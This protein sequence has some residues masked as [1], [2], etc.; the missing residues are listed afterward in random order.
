MSKWSVIKLKDLILF[1]IPGEWGD[2]PSGAGN[3][4]VLRAADFT[5]DC[6]LRNSVGVI[7]NIPQIKLPNRLLKNGDI[8]IEKSGGSPEQPVGRIAF[9]DR[10]E[11]TQIYSF[12]NFLQLLRVSDSFDKEFVYYLM[13]Y[14]YHSGRVY[15][16]QQQTTGIINLKLEQYLDEEVKIPDRTDE[17][18]KI[19][20]IL[21][22]SD[23][24]IE[25]TEALIHKYQQIKAG[26]MHDL[27]TRGLTAD[28]QLRPPREQAPDLYQETPIGWIPKD[29]G[30]DQFGERISVIDPNP[31]HR[32]P[33]EVEEG[34]PICSTEN[35]LGEN[36]FHLN[37]NRLVPYHTFLEQNI[38]CQFSP[39]DVVFARK[40]KIG[41]ARRYGI[42]KKAFSHTIV[43]MKPKEKNID[44]S[45]L[46]W[47]ARS[48]W[49][50]KAIE[51]SM[52]TNSG[53]P[54]LGVAFINKVKVPFPKPDDQNLMANMLDAISMNIEIESDQLEKYK[55]QKSGLMHDLLTGRVRVKVHESNNQEAAA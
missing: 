27:F 3:A 9:F 11:T 19:R 16:Y 45:W 41:L 23:Q 15:R 42:D 52:N 18:K 38:R 6:K 26:L 53:V 22:I 54:T 34:V 33:N 17:Q 43:I 12:S 10:E 30:T 14:L 5:K 49:L 48:D 31:S 44:S 24:A 8:L 35:F 25:K 55:K 7:R 32:Y 21:K 50:L 20:R 2:D 46:L 39:N 47:L 1:S 4:I 37:K 40:G 29:W 13:S 28:G 51:K 36:Q